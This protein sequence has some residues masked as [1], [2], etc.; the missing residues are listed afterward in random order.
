MSAATP[1]EHH[2]AEEFIKL[3]FRGILPI[4]FF[5]GGIVILGLRL[6]GWSLLLGTPI[7]ILGAIFLILSFDE[8]ARAAILPR[9]T[10][11]C[12]VCEKPTPTIPGEWEE[13]T[14]CPSCKKDI[15]RGIKREGKLRGRRQ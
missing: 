4:I 7:T 14:I 8:F 10:T 2:H 11:R 9:R 1:E 13:E 15:A 6:K 12:S 3:L 5:I